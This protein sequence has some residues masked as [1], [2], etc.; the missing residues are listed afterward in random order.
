MFKNLA[1]DLQDRFK[2]RNPNYTYQKIPKS[3]GLKPESEMAFR[4]EQMLNRP[5]DDRST[6]D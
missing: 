5:P 3:H 2:L 4:W 1:A 6:K